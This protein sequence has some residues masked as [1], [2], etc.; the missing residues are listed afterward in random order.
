MNEQANVRPGPEPSQDLEPS[1]PGPWAPS[2]LPPRHKDLFSH[3][4]RQTEIL[5]CSIGHRPLR[6]RCP[7]RPLCM[8]INQ[9]LFSKPS[10]EFLNENRFAS[11]NASC[12][13]P[14]LVQ[15]TMFFHF[16][17]GERWMPIA[18]FGLLWTGQND[19]PE[20]SIPTRLKTSAN[21]VILWK[22]LERVHAKLS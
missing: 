7:K 9:I 4:N 21:K 15:C 11:N 18:Y 2:P 20:M 3:T 22:E 19:M 5:P 13:S 10:H 6:V 1:P 17:L 14:V 8:D 12:L 16:L